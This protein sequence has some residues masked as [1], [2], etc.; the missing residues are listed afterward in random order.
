[1]FN[2]GTMQPRGKFSLE[3]AL[4][5]LEQ[6]YEF[7]EAEM[8]AAQV[9]WA[10][11]ASVVQEPIITAPKKYKLLCDVQSMEPRPTKTEAFLRLKTGEFVWASGVPDYGIASMDSRILGTRCLAVSLQDDGMGEFA[12]VQAQYL[13]L[14]E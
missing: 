6:K 14:V 10:I 1:M 12:S 11:A 3:C 8:V 2:E 9:E 7:Q 4:K 13:E 5:C